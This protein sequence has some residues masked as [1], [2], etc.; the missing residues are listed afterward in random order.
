MTKITIAIDGPAASGKSTVGAALAAKL[1]YLY[2]D[3][4]VMY[5]AVT[6]AAL[7]RSI[8]IADEEAVGRLAESLLI[9]VIPPTIQDGR[10]YTVLADDI[11]ITWAI[12]EPL[13]NRFVSPVSTYRRVRAAL[14]AQQ[15]RIGA[16]GAVVMVGRDIGSVV[17][18]EAEIKV[19]LDATLEERTRRRLHEALSRGQS[20]S[21]DD[22]LADLQRRD[23]SDS[24]RSEA[25][26]SVAP[27][28]IVVDTTHISIDEVVAQI[29]LLVMQVS[30]GSKSAT[31]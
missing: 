1:G 29:E 16:A 24:T 15:R 13:V 14:T 4:G 6:W 25:P 21:Y 17:L 18:P 31:L 28:A 19:Y 23:H 27:G 3:T 8:P 30:D 20:L 10:Q 22:V 9:K 26:L 12:R 5:R 11:D 2:F 7:E